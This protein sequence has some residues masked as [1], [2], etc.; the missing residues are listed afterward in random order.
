[1]NVSCSAC[2]TGCRACTGPNNVDCLACTD[3]TLYR[4]ITNQP[5]STACLTA[6]QCDDT[7]VS[8]FGDRTCILNVSCYYN[9]L[10]NYMSISILY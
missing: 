3:E 7:A 4:V 2:A 9:Q 1:M 6:A 10:V 5:S 8:A